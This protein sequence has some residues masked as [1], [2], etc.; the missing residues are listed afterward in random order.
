MYASN[1]CDYRIRTA[2]IV[3]RLGTARYRRRITGICEQDKA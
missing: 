1:G 2:D 3:F